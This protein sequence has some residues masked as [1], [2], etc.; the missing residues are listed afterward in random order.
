MLYLISPNTNLEIWKDLSCSWNHF[1]IP[2]TVQQMEA[3]TKQHRY[4][5]PEEVYEQV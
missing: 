4:L 1:V 2:V 5:P 3:K